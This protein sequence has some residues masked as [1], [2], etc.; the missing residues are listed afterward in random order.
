MW[1]EVVIQYMW[2][3]L[4]SDL[5]VHPQDRILPP[6]RN[7]GVVYDITRTLGKETESTCD[8]LQ[9]PQ[10]RGQGNRWG[11]GGHPEKEERGRSHPTAEAIFEQRAVLWCLPSYITTS[12]HVTEVLYWDS[13]PKAE[14]ES[15][16]EVKCNWTWFNSWSGFSFHKKASSVDHYRVKCQ[17]SLWLNILDLPWPWWWQ[18]FVCLKDTEVNSS[19]WSMSIFF[20]CPCNPSFN[21]DF[22]QFISPVPKLTHMWQNKYTFIL[23]NTAVYT[24]HVTKLKIDSNLNGGCSKLH[25][26]SH[27][28]LL[29]QRELRAKFALA[30]VACSLYIG[31][32]CI[33]KKLEFTFHCDTVLG[34]DRLTADGQNNTGNNHYIT[35]SNPAQ[36][37]R[38]V[39]LPINRDAVTQPQQL[40]F[41]DHLIC[42]HA[43]RIRLDLML[44]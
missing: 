7:T 23:I 16:P 18:F 29:F 34:P 13:D 15:S 21:A 40:I 8:W 25:I 20:L 17:S 19:F 22:P 33:I 35:G 10:W 6:E 44:N 43:D 42:W 4:A 31:F 38:W 37:K 11:V 9:H 14:Y 30:A 39:R 2:G 26:F 3:V 1:W 5:L 36:Q 24:S 12:Y 41:I 27:F 28:I 32:R